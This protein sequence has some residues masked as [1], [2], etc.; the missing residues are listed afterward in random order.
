MCSY[1]LLG[2]IAGGLGQNLVQS[3]LLP[4]RYTAAILMGLLLISLGVSFFFGWSWP[5]KIFSRFGK[6]WF[7]PIQPFL[8]RYQQQKFLLGFFTALLPCG[9]LYSFVLIAAATK[10]VWL[11]G[12]TMFIFWLG[13]VPALMLM[14]AGFR[15]IIIAPQP[16]VRKIFGFFFITAGLYSVATQIFLHLKT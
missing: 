7:K 4:L 10:S 14:S 11:G 13:T 12:M 2:L 15:R 9:W 3:Q 1:T 8:V 16:S 5:E 6:N